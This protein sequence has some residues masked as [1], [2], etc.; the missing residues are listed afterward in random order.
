MEKRELIGYQIDFDDKDWPEGLFSF[1][2]F[3]TKTDAEDFI[4][5]SKSDEKYYDRIVE[6]YEGDVEEPSFIGRKIRE[7][8]KNEKVAVET[9]R[10]GVRLAIVEI[11]Q[12]VEC[13][14]DL[15]GVCIL[16]DGF[17]SHEN[18]EM[19]EARSV[20]Q[21]AEGKVCPKCGE[22]LYVEH[23]DELGYPY[24]CPFC[25]ENFYGIELKQ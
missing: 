5:T 2:V 22:P 19:V 13:D 1:E 7:F 14:D 10:E 17:A 25:E 23:L 15:V 11:E 16:V 24:Y 18:F 20:Y 3:R 4:F 6:I 12:E 9:Q 8:E 21:L